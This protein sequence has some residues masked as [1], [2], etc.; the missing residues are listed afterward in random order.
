MIK[1]K[2]HAHPL[3]N[4]RLRTLS[5]VVFLLLALVGLFVHS[6]WGT[7]SAFSPWDIAALCPLGAIEVMVAEKAFIPRVLV[8]FAIAA[9]VCIVLGRVFCGW[10]CP[11]PLIGR[12]FGQ[13]TKVKVE[14]V[15]ATKRSEGATKSAQTCPPSTCSTCFAECPSQTT[16]RPASEASGI[17]DV[18]SS[19]ATTKKTKTRGLTL[20]D[21]GPYAVLAGAIGSSAIFG[22]PVFCLV[23]PVGL[24][25][26]TMIALWRVFEFNELSWS[27][28]FFVGFLVLELFVLRRWCH[29]FCP[30]GAVMTLLSRLN[31]TF[32]PTVETSACLRTKGLNCNVCR[33]VCPENI[34][35]AGT[36]GETGAASTG[37]AAARCTKC[38]A[39]ADACPAHAIRFPIVPGKVNV[40]AAV[41]SKPLYKTPATP[42]ILSREAIRMESARCIECGAC[43]HACPAGKDIPT[44]MVLLR[45]NA[46]DA[47]SRLMLAP[48][49]FPEI[50]GRICPAE[51]LCESACPVPMSQGGPIQIQKLERSVVAPVLEADALNDRLLPQLKRARRGAAIIGAGPAGLSCAETL[52]KAGV[53]VTIFDRSP[54]IGGL[55]TFGIPA[56]K[57]EKEL[58]TARRRTLTRAGA[59][60]MLGVEVGRDVDTKTLTRD[61]CAVFLGIGAG[62]AVLANIKGAD[63][64]EVLE[65][66]A[67]LAA[68]AR[69]ALPARYD[70]AGQIASSD[71]E[72]ISAPD[73][74]Q[75][76][77]V[78]IG[79]GD[80]AIDCLRTALARGAAEA[81]CLV[82]RDKAHMRALPSERALAEREG[83]KFLYETTAHQIV[84]D[85]QGKISGVELE[86]KVASTTSFWPCDVV[87]SACGFRPVAPEWL[88][89][90]GV[91]CDECGRI[92]LSANHRTTNPMVFAG[93][94]AVRG[95]ALAVNALTDGRE[96]ALEIAREL[97]VTQSALT[98][99]H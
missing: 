86:S 5:A 94:D 92:R 19:N 13:N 33:S 77:V 53:P 93:G 42:E 60:W 6:G 11:V 18:A 61:F 68:C 43:A 14:K 59:K 64:P 69:E 70:G 73:M 84:F 51:R 29:R 12:L 3:R 62:Q 36:V 40:P 31:R 15:E 80:T 95:P 56:F 91:E 46:F 41:E 4:K 9:L 99:S 65:A 66:G 38:H 85:D 7:A 72:T 23:C 21:A 2:R 97:G 17:S 35:L 67:F 49:A 90:L 27:I 63:S 34:S 50:C 71:K 24:T 22:F 32:R 16:K 75:R 54:E 98:S 74:R 52:L 48:G 55:L 45:E 37:L 28:V 8:G 10:L 76:R 39:C 88:D 1:P 79:A 89:T 44:W 26:A 25:F 78:V 47:A 83:A 20:D 87:I 58:L 30:L 57:L 82:R 96:A 81:I